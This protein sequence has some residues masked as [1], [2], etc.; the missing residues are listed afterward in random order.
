MRRLTAT[1]ATKLTACLVGSMVLLFGFLGYLN[2]RLHRQHLEEMVF[3]SADRISDLIRRS[4][5]Y[6]MLRDQREEAFQIIKTIGTQPGISKVRIFNKEGRITLSTDPEEV[7]KF[8][9]KKA[10]ACYAC[11][12]QAQPLARLDRPTACAFTWRETASACWA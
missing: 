9:D 1:L 11:H 8:V 2:L 7:G 3:L 10:E 4:I 5:R 6:S 12:A